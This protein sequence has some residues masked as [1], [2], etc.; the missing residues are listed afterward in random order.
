M[1]VIPLTPIDAADDI[2]RRTFM[3]WLAT[4]VAASG[5]AC[6][7]PAAEI[8]PYINR[9]DLVPGVPVHFAT[10][11]ELGG[12]A[13]GLVAESREGR[14]IKV[15]GN[16]DHPASLGA[17][18]VFHQ[19]S[20]FQL[21]DPDRAGYITRRGASASWTD[22]AGAFAPAPLARQVG[23]DGRGLRLLLDPTASPTVQHL[24]DEI[25]TTYPAAR[26]H[27]YAPLATDAAARGTTRVFGRPLQPIYD[28]TGAGIT[29][30]AGAD[31]VGAGPFHLRYARQIAD[32]RRVRTPGD[33]MNRLYAIEGRY[34][35]TGLAADHRLALRPTEIVAALAALLKQ[36]DADA[37]GRAAGLDRIDV[38]G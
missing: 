37:A 29:V 30:A 1:Q 33:S 5:A 16:P 7:K 27:A 36:V 34:T 10:A 25:K 32:R 4:L 9:P 12:Y 23:Q 24:I 38:H 13:T 31:I 18:G 2:G 19:A 17:A 22:V 35:P 3:R 26:V 6:A 28:F 14:P 21:Y 11:M 15:E 20:T 8:V